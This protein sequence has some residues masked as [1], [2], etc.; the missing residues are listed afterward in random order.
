MYFVISAA[1]LLRQSR[2]TAIAHTEQITK[3]VSNSIDVYISTI[4][5]L[6]D[7]IVRE[8]QDTSFTSTEG[9]E[10][11]PG[12]NSQDS[13][14][15]DILN[16]VYE[17]HPEIAGILVS[18]EQD[19]YIGIGMSRISR[20]PFTKEQWYQQTVATPEK[21]V[22]HSSAIGRNI[23]TDAN[24]SA[25]DVF[26]LS[27][28]IMDQRTGQVLGVLLFDIHHTIIQDSINQVTIG[29]NG[30]VFVVDSRNNI[31]YAP[32]NQ[33]V[34]RV[35]LDWLKNQPDNPLTAEIEGAQYQIRYAKSQY[36]GWKTIGVFPL[37]EMM[38]SFD[39]S[40]RLVVFSIVFAIILV[41]VVSFPIANSVTKPLI[42]L[43]QLMKQAESGDLSVRFNSRYSDEIGELGKRFNNM[44]ERID[45]L[46]HMVYLEQQQKR[47]A[48]IKN[49]QLQ[50]KP[51][52][53]Y[54][55]L[56]TIGWMARDHDADDV[57]KLIDALSNM[58]RIGLS[59]GKENIPL[60]E[61]I[62]HV[63]N[64]LYIQKIRYKEKLDYHIAFDETLSNFMV[65]KLILQP[66]VENAIYHGIK[67]KPGMGS[68]TVNAEKIPQSGVLITVKDNG[69]GMSPDVLAALLSRLDTEAINEDA[70]EK[71][72]GFGLYYVKARLV[73]RYGKAFK[74]EIF[75]SIEN[76]TMISL[77]L[78]FELSGFDPEGSYSESLHSET[79]ET[80]SQNV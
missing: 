25:D 17:S 37:K 28:A 45:R 34:Y 44:V 20:D 21:V 32:V 51:H 5:K 48:E 71:K 23:V 11:E 54:N 33:I 68:I 6:A 10:N 31:V 70:P 79:T 47:I 69:A 72:S 12:W 42:K 7:F 52:F 27:K 39:T 77:F 65:P 30:F 41:F 62:R 67:V 59:S 75:S 66:L 16:N 2:D 19:Q 9:S 14:I 4:D 35:N 60:T 53:L 46:I 64:Y 8:L 80:D 22:L 74:M 36:T 57:V 61:E 76:G 63:S 56:D 58:Y 73:L 15:F 40:T 78:P 43:Q 26:S 38:K 18:S 50:I 49:L 24:Y 55:T 3:Q 13:T 29:Q 1:I